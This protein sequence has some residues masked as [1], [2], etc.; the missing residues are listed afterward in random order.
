MF[1]ENKYLRSNL[2]TCCEVKMINGYY[3]NYFILILPITKKI[4]YFVFIEH[5][6]PLF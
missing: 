6:K 1:G 2:L 4:S 3:F 5:E